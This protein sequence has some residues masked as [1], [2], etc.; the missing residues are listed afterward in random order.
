MMI[1]A[2]I[3]ESEDLPQVGEGPRTYNGVTGDF[4]GENPMTPSWRCN[5]S[6]ATPAAAKACAEAKLASEQ[7]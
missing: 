2:W 4:D 5:H 7:A 3:S 6:H 1:A